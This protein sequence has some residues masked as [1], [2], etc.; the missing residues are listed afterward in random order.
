MS[1]RLGALLLAA[2]LAFLASAFTPLP[3]GPAVVLIWLAGILGF[4][5]VDAATR[6]LAL[7]LT[8]AGVIATIWS[9]ALGAGFDPVA[10]GGINLPIIALFLGVAFLSLVGD[11]V[12]VV[13]A[14][15]SR[16]RGRLWRTMLS[17]HLIGAVINMSMVAIAGDRMARDGTLGRR[18]AILLA[19]VYCAAA[20]WSPFF[21]AAAVA[22]TY[23]PDARAGLFIPLGMLGALCAFMLTAREVIRLDP[24]APLPDFTP[25][26]GALRLTFALLGAALVL[27]A[28]RA[29]MPMVVIVAAVTPP[30]ALLL[31]PRMEPRVLLQQLLTR[32]LPA[33]SSQVV[34]FLAAGV[35][36]Y[37]ISQWLPLQL[38]AV[39][40]LPASVPLVV[41][42]LATGLIILAA[43]AGMHPLI[44]IAA[45]SSALLPAGAEH[46]LLAFSFLAGWAVG[47]AVAPLSGMNLFLIGRYRLRAREIARW[48]PG[49]AL[50]MLGVVTCLSIAGHL[51]LAA[52]V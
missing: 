24:E 32:T 34:L 48:G 31:M 23:A 20:F 22:H 52:G 51:L 33:T 12:T 9:L 45:L 29:D 50:A 26:R 5:E 37:G 28:V 6:R 19:R 40:L 41:Y 17:I 11:A 36:A 30:L 7:I 14:A 8:A 35:F 4:A 3:R 18:E 49:Y 15:G 27:K 2:L 44:S 47:T 13:P 42:P 43:Y 38:E 46:S 16:G 21:V 39:G 10:M 25:D 1:P